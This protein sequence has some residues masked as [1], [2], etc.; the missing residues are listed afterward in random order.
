MSFKLTIPIENT[1]VQKSYSQDGQ[2][3]EKRY[4][5]GLASGTE[6]DRDS[7]RMAESA[8]HAMREAIDKG[9]LSDTGEVM[10]VPL[11]NEHRKETLEQLGWLT[12][13][14]LQKGVNDQGKD[15]VE[16][17]IEAELDEDNPKAHLLFKKLTT[18]G[19][20]NRPTLLGL[21]ISGTVRKMSKVFDPEVKK[22]IN[23]FDDIQLGEV[24]VVTKPSYSKSSS[25]L[26]TLA[27]SYT[28]DIE[29][30]SRGEFSMDMEKTEDLI[31]NPSD[32]VEKNSVTDTQEI[33]K[34]TS[35]ES[36]VSTDD[37]EK[38]YNTRF[39]N[40]ETQMSEIIRVVGEL[41]SLIET[42]KTVEVAEQKSVTEESSEEI[43]EKSDD[44]PDTQAVD[45]L[46][47]AVSDTIATAL[48]PI[49]E[50]L[51]AM[52]EKIASLEKP[53][54]KSFAALGQMDQKLD[55][56]SQYELRKAAAKQAGQEFDPLKEALALAFPKTK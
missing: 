41:R 55:A 52:D 38:A 12:K 37:V 28:G 53:V 49:V 50:K 10:Q 47:S 54:D 13:A 56:N 22:T 9:I 7:E 42:P 40:I 3:V 29:D 34:E 1:Y 6:L 2:E 35:S 5:T 23:V 4:I 45:I 24:S 15:V 27:K 31:E 32:G 25:Y 33:E 17:W 48:N 44:T 8:L 21:S 11:Y 19:P 36:T 18:P 20:K 51:Q 30:V 39:T 16:M 43:V 46:K 14:W 26:E